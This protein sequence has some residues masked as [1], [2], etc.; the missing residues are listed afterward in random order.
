MSSVPHVSILGFK[1]T[2]VS[3]IHLRRLLGEMVEGLEMCPL[4]ESAVSADRRLADKH[5][6]APL[7]TMGETWKGGE[8]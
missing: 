2:L 6:W 5:C 8:R 4:G 1:Q 7:P 3:Q